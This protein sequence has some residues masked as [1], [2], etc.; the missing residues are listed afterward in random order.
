MI[1]LSTLIYEEEDHGSTSKA[2]QNG[3]FFSL[4]HRKRYMRSRGIHTHRHEKPEYHNH[5]PNHPIRPYCLN[6]TKLD[7]YALRTAAPKPLCVPAMEHLEKFQIEKDSSHQYFRPPCTN[8]DHNRFDYELCGVRRGASNERYQA[9]TFRIPNERYEHHIKI[10]TDGSKKDE[11][12]G[13]AVVLSDTTIR[14]RQFTIYSAE[15]SAIIN[16]LYYTTNYNQKRVIITDSLNT[17]IGVSDKKR[18]KNPKAQ[19]IRKL[20]DQTSTNIT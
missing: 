10:N 14:R 19:L 5:N 6:P 8:I 1:I 7:K 11:E 20:I 13:Y 18:S 3:S 16:V 4:P 17:I 12:V 2:V 9:K 15:Q